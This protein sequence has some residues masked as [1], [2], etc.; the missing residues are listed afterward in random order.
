MLGKKSLFNA[1]SFT[2]VAILCLLAKFACA[3]LAVKFSDVNLPNSQ[4]VIYLA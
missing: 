3:S 4:V 1:I 2:T